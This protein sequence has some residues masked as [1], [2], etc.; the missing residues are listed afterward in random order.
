M[1]YDVLLAMPKTESYFGK[2]IIMFDV[3]FIPDVTSE[4]FLDFLGSKVANYTINGFL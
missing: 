2:V 3:A 1:T 4:I